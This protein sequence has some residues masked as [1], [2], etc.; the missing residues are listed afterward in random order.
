[1]QTHLHPKIFLKTKRRYYSHE[2]TGFYDK[3][4]PKVDSNYTCLA[5]VLLDF[6]LKKNG[7][8]YPQVFL[9]EYK[10][11]NT[12]KEKV[13]RHITEYLVNSSDSDESDEEQLIG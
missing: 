11:V 10:Y 3:E 9:K 7:N 13:I 2:A 1:M 4:A 8:F 12:M 5:V 6:V